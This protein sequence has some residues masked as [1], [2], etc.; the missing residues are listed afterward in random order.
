MNR[1]APTKRRKHSPE[2]IISNAEATTTENTAA[3]AEQGAQGAP[4]KASPKKDASQK[5]GAKAAK[6]ERKAH[7]KQ[8]VTKEPA[9]PAAAVSEVVAQLAIEADEDP[10]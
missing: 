1:R 9:P 8:A 10:E 4:E 5:K 6:K 7:T 2:T 3:V